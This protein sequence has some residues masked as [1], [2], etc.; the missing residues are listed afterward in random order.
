VTKPRDI[1]RR[2]PHGDI[3]VA[4]IIGKPSSTAL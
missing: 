1:H 3:A 4:T 2:S